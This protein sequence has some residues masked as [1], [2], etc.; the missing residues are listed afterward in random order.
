MSL[1]SQA[2]SKQS[3]SSGGRLPQTVGTGYLPSLSS[4]SGFLSLGPAGQQALMQAYGQVPWLFSVVETIAQS[5]ASATW[6]LYQGQIEVANHPALTLWQNPGPYMTG[7]AFREAG[8]QHLELTGEWWVVVLRNG[9][10]VP[11][12]FQLIR[13]DRMTVVPHPTEIIA[14]YIYTM[15]GERFPLKP[16]EVILLKRPN[17]MDPYRG[18]GPV[19][20]L[21]TDLESERY[22]ARFSRAFFSNSAEPGGVIEFEEELSDAD[23]E[24]FLKRWEEMHKGASNAHR[25]AVLERGKWTGT[26]QTMRNMQFAD[27]RKFTQDLVL[28]AY[29]MPRPIMGITESV[30][31]ANAEAA[32]VTFGRWRLK[33]RLDRIK[34]MLNYQLLPMFGP[35]PGLEFRYDN[36]VPDD[37]LTDLAEATQG[38]TGGILTQ[39]E[40]RER[41]DEDILP[42]GDEIKPPPAPGLFGDLPTP[43][44]SWKGWKAP[45]NDLY[46]EELQR[47]QRQV[48]RNWAARLV[49]EREAITLHL[50]EFMARRVKIEMGDVSSYDWNWWDKYSDEVIAELA[51]MAAASITVG[52]TDMAPSLV[53]QLASEYARTRGAALLRLDGEANLVAFTRRRVNDL[54]AQTIDEGWGLDKLRRALQDDVAFSRQRAGMVARTETATALGQGQRA[55][56]IADGRDEKRWITQGASDPRVDQVCLDNEAQGWIPLGDPFKS[57]HDTIPAH[58]SCQCVCVYRHSG[59]SGV[60]AEE[61]ME[62]DTAAAIAGARS[63]DEVRCPG[64][65]TRMP[66]SA[67]QGRS[68]FQCRK[69]GCKRQFT[70]STIEPGLEVVRKYVERDAEGRILAI[71]EERPLSGSNG[72]VH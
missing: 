18:L 9:Q 71:R 13:P 22:A 41:L 28:G 61:A 35:A 3:R 70:F 40:A 8:Q 26:Q 7:D 59:G 25:V 19:Q 32:E 21:M 15:G 1:L 31:R 46:G 53:Q 42:G 44:R 54:V 29:G 47:R 24:K 20:A 33:P 62:D 17:P 34:A 2:L 68:V 64:C 57:G 4:P 37:R 58:P 10:G 55:A 11:V 63:V 72:R 30:N 56:A 67:F 51:S 45:A 36:P 48:E 43:S 5:V 60:D 6:R 16:E 65:Q 50:R 66:V 14:G 69:T 38:Y 49:R 23:W 39:N 52:F 12:E 27:L